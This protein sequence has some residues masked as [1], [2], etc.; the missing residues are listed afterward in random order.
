[1][2]KLEN[3]VSI[4]IETW[5][6]YPDPYEIAAVGAVSLLTGDEFYIQCAPT[7]FNDPYAV[8]PL[9]YIDPE[10][11]AIHKLSPDDHS[12]VP[13]QFGA[14]EF[15]EWVKGLPKP[16]VA[17]TFSSFDWA[18]L[19]P[20]MHRYMKE[21]PFSHSSLEMKSLYMGI[22]GTDWRSTVKKEIAQAQ[23][24]LMAGL[25]PHTHN[26]LD[27]AKEQGELLRRMLADSARFTILRPRYQEWVKTQI[28]SVDQI[29]MEATHS[30]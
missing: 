29:R 12:N 30:G 17:A 7:K 19:Y 4:D 6:P 13:Q 28:D 18:F 3:I 20:W 10:S 11:Q 8:D 1:M 2:A 26:A 23:P 14:R 9:R 25:P 24:H 27:D 21:S 22:Y 5:G 15:V 16:R